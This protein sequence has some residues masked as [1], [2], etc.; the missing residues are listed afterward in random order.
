M[1]R[2]QTSLPAL[3]IALLVLTVVTGL[4]LA[5]ADGALAGAERDAEERRVA[6]SLAERLVSAE[7]P[8]TER[9]N[10]L[11]ATRLQRLD[12]S[13]VETAFPVVDGHEVRIQVNGSTV[14]TTGEVS[15]GTT[16]RRLV[17][18]ERHQRRTMQ[19]DLGRNRAV[20]LPRRTTGAT[21]EIAPPA[22]T[23]VTTVRA[24]DR[25]LLRNTSG[26]AGQFEVPLSR[27]ETTEL[28]FGGAGELPGGS[29]TIRYPAPETTRTTLV[30]TVDG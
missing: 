6:S 21:L 13:R 27:F 23:T 5:I 22:N 24:N 2:G 29:V 14:A 18:V 19:P 8:L 30:V 11:N 20:T 1:T 10:V 4:G 3:A 16:I 9:A 12:T 17:V 15:T 26:L 25:V 7:S 28:R